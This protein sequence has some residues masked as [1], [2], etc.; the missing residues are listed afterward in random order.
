MREI[1]EPPQADGV[2]PVTVITGGWLVAFLV[3]LP[4]R[5]RLEA[6]GTGWWLWTCLAGFGLGV[7]GRWFLVRR[8]DAYRRAGVS[9]SGQ[10]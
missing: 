4:L 10:S 6:H 3:L 2:L 9:A 1:P 7:L 8:R 5:S